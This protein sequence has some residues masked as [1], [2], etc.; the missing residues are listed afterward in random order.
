MDIAYVQKIK[1]WVEYDNIIT[2]HKDDVKE[3]VEKKKDIE[4]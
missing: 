1:K 3:V 4:D 2:K